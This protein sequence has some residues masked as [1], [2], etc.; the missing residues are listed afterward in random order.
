MQD[1]AGETECLS[2]VEQ[3]ATV[4]SNY[5]NQNFLSGVLCLR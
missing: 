2:Q 1:E 4:G 3:G 5:G